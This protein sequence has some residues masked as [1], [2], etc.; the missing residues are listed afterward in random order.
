MSLKSRF[1]GVL[2]NKHSKRDQRLLKSAQRYL[3]HI[4]ASMSTY[5]SVKNS[6]LVVCKILRLFVNTLT[7]DDKYSLLYRD[8]FIQPLQILLS[9]KQKTFS[10]FFLPFLKS[11]LNFEHSRKKDG[12]H[13]RCFSQITVSE[14][15]DYLNACK[16]PFQRSLPQQTWQKDAKTVEISTTLPLP[17]LFIHVAIIQLQKVYVSALQVLKTVF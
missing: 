2:H 5:F 1:R 10:E 6:M 9:Q 4:F 3:Y 17:Y 12:P 7:D 11:T 13:S 16:I 15:G 8:N 14:K